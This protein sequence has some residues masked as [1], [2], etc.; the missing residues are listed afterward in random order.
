M[1]PPAHMQPIAVKV[2]NNDYFFLFLLGNI[3]WDLETKESLAFR[4]EAFLSSWLV[5]P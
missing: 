2:L 4:F 3:R 1:V 5:E